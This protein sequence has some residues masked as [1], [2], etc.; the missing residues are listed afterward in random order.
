METVCLDFAD[1]VRDEPISLYKKIEDLRQSDGTVP[2]GAA[3]IEVLT[4][5]TPCRLGGGTPAEPS[6][7]AAAPLSAAACY[8]FGEP[9]AS[10][11]PV[12]TTPAAG[13]TKWKEVPASFSLS[14]HKRPP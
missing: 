1:V 12:R 2:Q 9:N 8:E 13:I 4:A 7:G 5:P 6:R 3:F 11:E 14:T 10:P